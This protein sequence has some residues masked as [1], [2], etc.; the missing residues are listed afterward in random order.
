MP[1]ACFLLAIITTNTIVAADRPFPALFQPILA[2]VLLGQFFAFALGDNEVAATLR[3]YPM[4]TAN[5]SAY[6]RMT[7]NQYLSPR[8]FEKIKGR[9]GIPVTDYRVVSVGIAPAVA[10]GN[11]IYCLDAYVADYPLSYKKKFRQ[12]VASELSLNEKWRKYFDNWGSRCYVFSAALDRLYYGKDD[13]SSIGS[14]ALSVSG[15]RNIWAGPVFV[16][17]A[18]EITD[19]RASGLTLLGVFEDDASPWRI[20]LYSMII[21]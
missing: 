18:V 4:Q 3:S 10:A 9:I 11:G 5:I 2:V 19:P 8:L 7:A 21:S 17:S 14:I 20:H 12:I 1:F 13:G 6:P 16:V 15:I